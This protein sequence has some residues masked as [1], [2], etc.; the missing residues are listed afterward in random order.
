MRS[1]ALFFL[2]LA[3]A[4]CSARPFNG[5]DGTA[6]DSQ[7]AA[8][9]ADGGVNCLPGQ[10][11]PFAACASLDAGAT[12]T[13][14]DDDHTR[15]GVC[16]ATG[17]GRL[18]CGGGDDDAEA[19]AGDQHITPVGVATAA[20][21]GLDAG[22]SCRFPIPE[23]DLMSV[24]DEAGDR[25]AGDAGP[26]DDDFMTGT[27]TLLPADGGDVLA[28]IP[29]RSMMPEDGEHGPEHGDHGAVQAALGA[30]LNQAAGAVC[31]FTFG[32]HSVNGLCTALPSGAIACAPTC[33][34]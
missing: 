17:N 32:E 14:A 25:D 19:D 18:V 2:S 4:A 1:S 20:C 10:P 7:L 23:R 30:C 15:T 34:Q 12:C 5:A 11:P 21:E 6:L 9:L 27:C 13:V 28:C 29:G 8:E 16:H 33:R 22:A 26:D 24:A 31:S 3:L